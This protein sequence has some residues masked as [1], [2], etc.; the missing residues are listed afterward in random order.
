MGSLSA[1][2]ASEKFSR[3]GTFK[4]SIWPGMQFTIKLF[5]GLKI[6]VSIGNLVDSP[7]HQYG[8]SFFEYKYLREFKA[9]IG[10]ARN[11]V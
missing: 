10:T 9:K 5:K 4:G 7:T 3:L 11:V 1:K 2:N 8:V 6:F